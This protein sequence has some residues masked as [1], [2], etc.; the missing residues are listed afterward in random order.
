MIRRRHQDDLAEAVEGQL[1][2]AYRRLLTFL[3]TE[4]LPR[5]RDKFGLSGIPGGKEMYLYLVK[6]ETTSDLSP[7]QIHGLGLTEL[8]RIETELS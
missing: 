4:Y 7:I 1:V 3:K 2:P 8:K 6:S 5:A